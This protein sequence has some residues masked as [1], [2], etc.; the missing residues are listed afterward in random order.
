MNIITIDT[1][2]NKKTIWYFGL[3]PIKARYTEQLSTRW[4]PS[5]FERYK[6]EVNFI[7][8]DGTYDKSEQ[9]KVGA[10]LDACGR[11][12][13][14]M[15]QCQKFLSHLSAGDIKDGDVIYLQDF[16][17]PG[18]ES[19]FYALDLYKIKVQIYSMLHAQSVDEYDFT[20][21]MREWMKPIEIGISRKMDGI[22]VGSTIHK[23]QLRN[24]GFDCPIH[25]VSLPFGKDDTL[26]LV[27][28]G[29]EKKQ[30]VIFASRLDKEKNPYFLL[31]VI[32][33]FL[34]QNPAWE[35]IITTSGKEFRSNLPGVVEL[36]ENYSKNNSRLKLL[37]DLSKEQYYQTIAESEIMF[38]SSLQDY[39]SWTS[40]EA[41]TFGTR[42]I[43]PNFRSFPDF[44]DQAFMYRPFDVISA[45]QL[46]NESVRE[47]V[48]STSRDLSNISDLGRNLE[49]FIMVNGIN[50]EVNIWHEYELCENLLK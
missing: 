15:S 5:A 1:T 29:Y 14:A 47:K 10:V 18:I 28:P 19:I 41:H 17:H 12:M 46:L 32:D 4:I 43:C 13:F 44:C 8:L 50:F 23:D 21:Q 39:V 49:A 24:Y 11:G 3:E 34:N 37:S 7:S 26:K 16:W 25:V 36:F 20:Y 2:K 33:R 42:F 9:I 27:K 31:E 35:W 40:I 22:F 6:D 38:N 30:Q 48:Q 45:L